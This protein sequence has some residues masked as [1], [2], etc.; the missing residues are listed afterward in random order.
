[1]KILKYISLVTMLIF[2]MSCEDTKNNLG[3]EYITVIDSLVQGSTYFAIGSKAKFCC[4][5]DTLGFFPVKVTYYVTKISEDVVEEAY[6]VGY[7]FYI[8][9]E[10][11]ENRTYQLAERK[12]SL[13]PKPDDGWKYM[14][15]VRGEMITDGFYPG[16]IYYGSGI[17]VLPVLNRL[18][19]NAFYTEE[20]LK[21]MGITLR[22]V[23]G[24]S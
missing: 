12:I 14:A 22:K 23:D 19:I 4:D 7:I 10:P 21:Q 2:A 5:P 17:L 20:D 11:G 1:M 6:F 8:W 9:G 16:N 13:I 24:Q 18:R 15:Q 3:E